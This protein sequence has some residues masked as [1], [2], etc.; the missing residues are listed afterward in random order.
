MSGAWTIGR[1]EHCAAAIED[2]G[3]GGGSVG[4]APGVD[5]ISGDIARL[6]VGQPKAHRRKTG[7]VVHGC[8]NNQEKCAGEA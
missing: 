1:R 5:R 7:V 2:G 8:R 6:T 4:T 3:F